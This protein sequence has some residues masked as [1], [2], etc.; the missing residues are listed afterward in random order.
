MS[1]VSSFCFSRPLGSGVIFSVYHGP[2]IKPPPLPPPQPP[3]EPP[4]KLQQRGFL[5]FVLQAKRR[6][7]KNSNHLL[8]FVSEEEDLITYSLFNPYSHVPSV[9]GEQKPA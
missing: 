9:T 1:I 5:R 8:V 2:L 6:K 3:T 4:G 7:G